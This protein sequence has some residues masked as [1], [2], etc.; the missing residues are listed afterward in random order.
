MWCNQIRSINCTACLVE[1]N[2]LATDQD[3]IE[4]VSGNSG[5][6]G[7]ISGPL[8]IIS[9]RLHSEMGPSVDRQ[10]RVENRDSLRGDLKKINKQ[11]MEM[12]RK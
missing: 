7:C 3:N 9:T 10:E 5:W 6:E 11:V 4:L 12:G 2:Q 1:A 8:D